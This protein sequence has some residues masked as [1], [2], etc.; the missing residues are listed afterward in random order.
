MQPWVI[1]DT[2]LDSQSISNGVIPSNCGLRENGWAGAN[3]FHCSDRRFALGT[4]HSME[5]KDARPEVGV[6]CYGVGH[7]VLPFLLQ[8]VRPGSG[9]NTRLVGVKARQVQPFDVTSNA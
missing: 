2:V 6:D 8:F 1:I 7:L 4:P 5:S 3:T 9:T